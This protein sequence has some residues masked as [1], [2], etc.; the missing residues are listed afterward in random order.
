MARLS[1]YF[2]FR[3]D[4]EGR[5]YPEVYL[6][7]NAWRF[8]R[9]GSIGPA[10]LCEITHVAT[11]LPPLPFCG[12]RRLKRGTPIGSGHRPIDRHDRLYQCS[13]LKPDCAPHKY[14]RYHPKILLK[15]EKYFAFTVCMDL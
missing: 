13:A 11:A 14:A 6:R 2:A 7:G 5:G 15:K 9:G 12:L 10:G 4:G 3:R 1:H 8:G